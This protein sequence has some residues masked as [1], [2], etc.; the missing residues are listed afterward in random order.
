MKLAAEKQSNDARLAEEAEKKALEEKQKAEADQAKIDKKNR[1]VELWCLDECKQYRDGLISEIKEMMN[2]YLESE[3]REASRV[4]VTN[5]VLGVFKD[6]GTKA[7]AIDKNAVIT[8]VM[9]AYDK[10]DKKSSRVNLQLNNEVLKIKLDKYRAV[11]RMV[12]AL[13]DPEQKDSQKRLANFVAIRNEE[14]PV[15]RKLADTRSMDFLK[16]IGVIL[17]SIATLGFGA[18]LAYHSLLGE[19][20]SKGA[21]LVEKTEQ[22]VPDKSPRNSKKGG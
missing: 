8:E 22:L 20:A 16:K 11:C 13:K 3:L 4:G 17:F 14:K 19:S 6:I 1:I 15:L 5:G 12:N 10:G 7:D 2:E 9:N 18:Y 21:L